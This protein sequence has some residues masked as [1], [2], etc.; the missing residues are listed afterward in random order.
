MRHALVPGHLIQQARAAATTPAQ[1]PTD[2]APAA[3][4]KSP[5]GGA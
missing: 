4:D 5:G 1:A 3:A 2:S